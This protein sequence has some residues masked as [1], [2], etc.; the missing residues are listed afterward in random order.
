MKNLGRAFQRLSEREQRLLVFSIWT[1]LAIVFFQLGKQALQVSGDWS[2]VSQE[3]EAHQ[4][5]L[6]LKPA[7]DKALEEQKLE[8]QEESYDK[9]S[10]SNMASRLS[11]QA[12]RDREY[13][14]LDSDE[15]DRYSQH[16]VRITFKDASYENV[17][18]FASLIR[19]QS[20]Y[21]FLSEVKIEPNY[22]KN[23]SEPI[24][25][26]AVFEVSSVEFASQ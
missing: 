24:T 3:M 8:Q 6:G 2:L 22:P 7:I 25:F 16:K 19:E 23:T 17:Q 14:E 5:V 13:R 9:Q 1:I 4:S 10:L 26:D 15:R 21:M 18:E 20:P 11:D 12:F